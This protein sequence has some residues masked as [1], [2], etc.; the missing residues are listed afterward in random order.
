VFTLWWLVA[1]AIVRGIAVIVATLFPIL[2]VP[3]FSRLAP[4]GDAELRARLLALAARVR[5][6]AVD[7]VA[8]DQS[9]KSRTANAGLTG[10]G[11]TRRIILFDTLA[12]P[13]A[14]AAAMDRLADLDLAERNP[15]RLKEVRFH[16]HPAADRRIARTGA[17]S[18]G[19]ECPSGRV[20]RPGP[21]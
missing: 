10:I 3:L 20:A 12:D 17:V 18:A 8:A 6:P 21:G 19:L 13:A 5:V 15:S 14:F 4:L 2:I 9:P 1:A 16:S 7:I 11:R